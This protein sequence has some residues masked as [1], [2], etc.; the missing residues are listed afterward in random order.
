MW[1]RLPFRLTV[2]GDV[3]AERLDRVLKSVHSTT[4]IADNVLCYGNA[5]KFPM[6]TL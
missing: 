1:L 5:E 4:G 6:M 3:F 2:A